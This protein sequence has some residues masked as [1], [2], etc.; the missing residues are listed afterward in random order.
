MSA[1]YTETYV[2]T[3][4]FSLLTYMRAFSLPASVIEI[5]GGGQGVIGLARGM[6]REGGGLAVLEERVAGGRH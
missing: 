5:S 3:K 1:T 4:L 2:R 6:S